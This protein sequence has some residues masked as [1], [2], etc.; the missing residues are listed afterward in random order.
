MIEGALQPG[1]LVGEIVHPPFSSIFSVPAANLV[2]D[3]KILSGLFPL[4]SEAI[5]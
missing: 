4:V 5:L 1:D 2:M 3:A